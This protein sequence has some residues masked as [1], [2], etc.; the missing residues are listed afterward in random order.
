MRKIQYVWISIVR[1]RDLNIRAEWK[2][3]YNFQWRLA[4]P[5]SVHRKDDQDGLTGSMGSMESMVSGGIPSHLQGVGV[6]HRR[7]RILQMAICAGVLQRSGAQELHLTERFAKHSSWIVWIVSLL[8]LL[9]LL[10]V[11]V[12]CLGHSRSSELFSRCR[13]CAI[14][15]AWIVWDQVILSTKF[16]TSWHWRM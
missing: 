1:Y 14:S 15:Q 4:A 6:G 2:C 12:S 8:S 5:R 10:T 11:A 3:R 7:L 13:F 16:G 9:S